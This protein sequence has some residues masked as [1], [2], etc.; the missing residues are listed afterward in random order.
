MAELTTS[1]R[2]SRRQSPLTAAL[3]IGALLVGAVLGILLDPGSGAQADGAP[4]DDASPVVGTADCS[5]TDDDM[6]VDGGTAVIEEH[7]TCE[8]STSDDRVNGT[9]ELVV[10]SRLDDMTI[11]GTW[12]ATGTITTSDG[13]WEG[14]GQG[15]V[16]MT[17]NLPAGAAG[18][19]PA[20]FGEMRYVGDGS[21]AGLTF[22][23]YFA[24]TNSDEGVSGWIEG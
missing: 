4:P 18:L 21:H 15:V 11:G 24:G 6:R 2:S 8:L 1:S 22:R 13:T 23:Y 3:V 10:I 5:I 17:G 16:S 14:T 7:F 20:N 9:E 12:V 19:S